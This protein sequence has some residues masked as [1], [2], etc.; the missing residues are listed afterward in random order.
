[1]LDP[2]GKVVISS[3][4][5]KASMQPNTMTKSC[6]SLTAQTSMLSTTKVD[7]AVGFVGKQADWNA[8]VVLFKVG[9]FCKHAS[10]V[11]FMSEI[12]QYYY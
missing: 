3:V 6:E 11:A 10:S 12:F 9:F 1:M 7:I 5:A 8:S 4:F 2:Q